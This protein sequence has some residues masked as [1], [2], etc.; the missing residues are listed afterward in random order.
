MLSKS[1]ITNH[2]GPWKYVH[3]SPDIVTTVKILLQSQFLTKIC[4]DFVRYNH[5]FVFTVIVTIE[6]DSAT[7]NITAKKCFAGQ[8]FW[9]T[10]FLCSN[11]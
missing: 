8:Y 3:Y 5:D 1:V 10:N 9:C 11:M 7:N 6:F 4:S 2:L